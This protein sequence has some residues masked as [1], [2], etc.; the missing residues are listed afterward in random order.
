MK[1]T[2]II[3][4]NVV[5]FLFVILLLTILLQALNPYTIQKIPLTLEIGEKV[6]INVNTTEL[7]FSV[8]KPGSKVERTLTF[9][10]NITELIK[11]KV[12]GIPFVYPAEE[13]FIIQ[14]QQTKTTVIIAAPPKNAPS[15]NYTGELL[16]LSKEQ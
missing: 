4:L 13:E 2:N 5:L 7:T 10:S 14:P 1:K 15:K 11:L 6:G 9:T 16:I 12:I 3:L 8:V